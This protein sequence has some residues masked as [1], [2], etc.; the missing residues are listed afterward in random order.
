MQT[1]TIIK[2]LVIEKNINVSKS[3]F[4]NDVVTKILSKKIFMSI[5]VLPSCYHTFIN[6]NQCLIPMFVMVFFAFI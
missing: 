6:L 1:M 4:E 5:S 3:L 2:I